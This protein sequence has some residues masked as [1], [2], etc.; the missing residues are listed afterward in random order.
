MARFT[1]H[2]WSCA[3]VV[4]ADEVHRSHTCTKCG[5]DLKVCKTCRHY[6][7]SSSNECR[8]TSADYVHNKT[9]A[10]YCGY[11]APR[12]DRIENAEEVDDARAK[13]EALFKK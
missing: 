10:N 7:E 5:E 6:D 1:F 9:R 2:C 3:E 11:Y 4:E 13:L 12:Q 8:E